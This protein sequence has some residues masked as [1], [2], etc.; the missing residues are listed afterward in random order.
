MGK[1]ERRTKDQEMA[2]RLYTDP[3]HNPKAVAKRKAE[4]HKARMKKLQHG[5]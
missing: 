1:A 3:Y 4:Q 5:K 2:A